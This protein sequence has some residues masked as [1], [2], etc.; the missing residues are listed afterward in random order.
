MLDGPKKRINILLPREF[1]DR[2]AELASQSGYTLP[3]YIRQILWRY[4]RRLETRP[5]DPDDWWIIR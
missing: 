5:G 3:G 2:L 4:L 1:F